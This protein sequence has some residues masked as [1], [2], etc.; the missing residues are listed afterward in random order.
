MKNGLDLAAQGA[1]KVKEVSSPSTARNAST[2]GGMVR[3]G[4]S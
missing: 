4:G 1:G 2:I 3:Q